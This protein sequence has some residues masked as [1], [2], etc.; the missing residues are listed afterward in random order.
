MAWLSVRRSSSGL[1]GLV[2]A[3]VGARPGRFTWV[4]AV[5]VM[6]GLGS[7]AGVL[8]L[9]PLLGAV[10]VRERGGVAQWVRGAFHSVGLRPTL[11]A[12]LGVYV[13]V[14]SL[15]AA[16]SVY[17]SVIS[18]RYRLEFIDGLRRRLYAA[19]ARAQWR[20]LL[21]IRQSDVLAVLTSNAA[22]AG[23]AAQG[24][25]ALV[26]TVI[27]LAAQLGAAIQISAPLTGLAVLA[28]VALVAVV[29]PLIRRSRR[30][31]QELIGRNRAVLG[32]MTGFLDGLKLTKAYGREDAHVD[33]FAAAI[34]AA[35]RSQIGFARA[36]GIANGIQAMLT[37]LLLAVFVDVAV[38]GLHVPVA[39]LLVVAVVFTRVVSQ[40]GSLQSSMQ[41]V[42]QGLPA[43][44]EVVKLIDS[45][46]QAAEA[47][48]ATR[49]SLR[50]LRL[51]DGIALD[52][53]HF[54]YPQRTGGRAEALAGVSLEIPRGSMVALA[55]PSGA[56]KTTI[57]DL[58]AGLLQPTDGEVT[59]GGVRLSAERALAWRS[60]VALVPQ[61]PFLFHDTIEANLRWARPEANE[62]D[63][64]NVL[65]AAAATEFVSQ[66]PGQLNCIVGD[67]GM[68]L[69]GGERQRLALARALL[70]A[71]DLLILDEAT[72]SLDTENERAIRRAL[73]DLR[74]QTTMLVIAHRLSTA[75]EADE[76]V[77]LDAGRV[78]ETGS[79]SELSEL[80]MGRL[81]AL[82][83]AG[84]TRLT[85][86]SGGRGASP[87]G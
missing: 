5:Q 32:Q 14:S 77:V 7:A 74:G 70:R 31:G 3:L 81:Q 24:A 17:Q 11:V 46:E 62:L 67:R 57:A 60:S 66:L 56:G 47:S 8:L 43:F 18:M 87:R 72:S 53:V 40:L 38:R 58:V 33:A 16:L 78:I 82:I 4:V 1:R 10:G 27:V 63:L 36:N 37:A 71:P 59:V 2:R 9:V 84:A 80:P 54:T 19:I 61:D 23:M 35:R 55:G 34:S 52:R 20:H 50:P 51:G 41:Q 85:A 48:V 83:E 29:W 44:D 64:W 42:A 21:G 6:A 28:G 86:A 49:R 26:V 39:S 12:V 73:M 25:L 15:T 76:I 30:L 22:W 45:C 13:A 79:W 68:R 65:D 69:S 75:S